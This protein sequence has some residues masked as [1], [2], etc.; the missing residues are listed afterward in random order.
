MSEILFEVTKDHLDTGLRGYPVGYCMTSK[1]DPQTGLYYRDIAVKDLAFLPPE[2]VMYLVYS[3]KK[4]QDVA[5]KTFI[6]ELKERSQ[7]SNA[8]IRH[9]HALPRDGHPM[10]LL[11]ASL[12]ILGMLESTGDYRKDGMNLMAK[13]PHLVAT[14]INHHAGWGETPLPDVSLSY[15]DRFVQMLNVPKKDHHLMAEVFK[16]FHVLHLDHGGGNLSVFVGK[17][18]ASGHEDIFGSMSAA[19]SALEG[20]LHGKANQ[21]SLNFVKQVL[22]SLKED[23]TVQDVENY[24]QNLLD[25]KELVYGFGH[26]VLRVEDPRATIFYDYGKKHFPNHSLIQTAL[27]L[28]EAGPKVLSKNPKIS[29]PYP[30]VDGIS[31]SVLSAAGF[32]YPEYFTVLFGMARVIGITT[33][34][35]YERC[36]ARSGKGT[37]IVRPRYIYTSSL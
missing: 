27:K 18:V 2:E 1:V 28:R 11:S 7:L 33:Q 26:A 5:F 4:G 29:D 19:M 30:N 23:A 37:P 13:M 9:I 22:D 31:G 20:D 3:G 25:H 10:K 24:I 35:I 14:V 16:L 21:D 34:I 6:K 15:I 17:A 12:L 8:V 32:P 36:I